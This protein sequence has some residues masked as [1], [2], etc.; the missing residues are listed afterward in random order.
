MAVPF[1]SFP[2]NASGVDPVSNVQYIPAKR[3]P[4]TNDKY[5]SGTF[6]GDES[7]LPAVLYQ[8]AG[9]GNWEIGGN[10]DASTTTR[11][12]T[13]YSTYAELAAGGSSTLSTTS[14]DVYTYVN[15][16]A[17]AGSPAASETTAGIA[18]LATQGETNTGTDDTRIVTPFKLKTVIGNASYPGSFTTLGA[19]GAVTIASTGA[20]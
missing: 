14:A 2:F 17:I 18:E 15:S 1:S 6:W 5:P 8:S 7:T 19:S 12:I 10:T 3:A 20:V 11:G 13:E 4:T 16:V 9:G